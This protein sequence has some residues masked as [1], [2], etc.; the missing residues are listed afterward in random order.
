MA[1]KRRPIDV[2]D[3]LD[4][5]RIA[6]EVGTTGEPRIL[7]RDDKELAV[8]TPARRRS[9]KTGRKTG[10]LTKDDAL[11]KLVG[12]GRSKLP[13]DISANKHKYLGEAYAPEP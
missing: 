3:I 12:I 4:L 8:L 1:K 2:T 7:T 5:L 6:E 9:P 11:F 10:I 13:V